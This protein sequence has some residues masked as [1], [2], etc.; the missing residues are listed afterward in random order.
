MCNATQDISVHYVHLCECATSLVSRVALCACATSCPTSH[1]PRESTWITSPMRNA[2]HVIECWCVCVCMYV[3]TPFTSLN[4]DDVND[5]ARL[6]AWYDVNVCVCA[7]VCM[8]RICMSHIRIVSCECATSLIRNASREWVM[9]LMWMSHVTH[10]NESCEWVM[11][12]ICVT[13]MNESCHISEWVMLHIWMCACEYVVSLIQQVDTVVS[14][15]RMSHVTRMYTSWGACACA[16]VNASCLSYDMATE[17]YD[18]W[19]SYVAYMNESCDTYECV[20]SRM[21]CITLETESRH[22]NE[23]VT[24]R[25]RKSRHEWVS[26]V[27]RLSL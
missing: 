3:H 1:K 7:Y 11:A 6:F 25:T 18:T 22:T 4:V 15:V 13:D 20:M 27:S 16:Y 10:V 14:R 12:L 23:K 26:R 9:S 17:S 24:S 5:V 2:I 21:W 8:S 19:M